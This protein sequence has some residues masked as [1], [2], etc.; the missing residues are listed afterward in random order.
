MINKFRKSPT[1]P[2]KV[3]DA[4]LD[5]PPRPRSMAIPTREPDI[6]RS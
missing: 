1:L 4:V 3:I 2:T 6:P 5:I